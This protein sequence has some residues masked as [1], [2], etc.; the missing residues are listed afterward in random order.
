[1]TEKY[2]MKQTGETIIKTTNA[3][4]A[5]VERILHD[6]LHCCDILDTEDEQALQ[7]FLVKLKMSEPEI[8]F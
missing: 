8:Q 4:K 2:I 7:L 1:M 3:L 6:V 5:E